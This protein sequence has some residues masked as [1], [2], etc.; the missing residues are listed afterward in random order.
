MHALALVLCLLVAGSDAP[1][2]KTAGKTATTTKPTP[3]PPPPP[4]PAPAPRAPAPAQ[5]DA[6]APLL[7]QHGQRRLFIAAG[8]APSFVVSPANSGMPVMLRAVAK[9]YLDLVTIG[10]AQLQVAVPLGF[11][12]GRMTTAFAPITFYGFDLLPSIRASFLMLP[13]VHGYAEL[14]VGF[15]VLNTTAEIRYLGFSS[16]TGAGMGVRVAVGAEYELSDRFRFFA[17]PLSVLSETLT[18]TTTFNGSTLTA[19]ASSSQWALL[20]GASYRLW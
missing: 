1:T 20:V 4:A 10:P 16:A 3:P 19:T 12:T 18:T 15:G 8:L 13:Q 6:N 5:E 11:E 9:A 17:E 14:G 2:H 7:A